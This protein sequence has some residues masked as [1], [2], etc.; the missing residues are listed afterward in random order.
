MH[1]FDASRGNLSS[2]LTTGSDTN[3]AVQR[4]KMVRGFRVEEVEWLYYLCSENTGLWF[5]ICKQQ[6]C[7]YI[8]K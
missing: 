3:Q 8:N 5:R 6:G 1:L 4:Q 7:S 2:G